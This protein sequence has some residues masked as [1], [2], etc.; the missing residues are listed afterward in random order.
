MTNHSDVAGVFQKRCESVSG[1]ELVES[2]LKLEGENVQGDEELS[3]VAAFS[4]G[5]SPHEDLLAE[6]LFVDDVRGGVVETERV[7]QAR[8]EDVQWCCGMGARPFERTWRQKEPRQ[9]LC[10]GSTPTRVMWVD[11]TTGLDWS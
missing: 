2:F 10:V 6:D 9:R 1:G 7:K 4:A 11:Q 5:P 3:D 8:Q